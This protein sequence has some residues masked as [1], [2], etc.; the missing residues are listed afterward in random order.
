VGLTRPARW[1]SAEL[2]TGVAADG[3]EVVPE[4]PCAIRT[5]DSPD[6]GFDLRD[7]ALSDREHLATAFGWLH[8]LCSPVARI[9]HPDD[10]TV[11][12]EVLHEF[13]H[14]LLRHL[15]T[16]GEDAD[17]RPG[18]IKVLKDRPVRGAQRAM[19]PLGQPDDYEI[20]ERD[21][22]LRGAVRMPPSGGP[23]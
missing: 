23:P 12:F 11:G 3:F 2:R 1:K 7:E 19:P 22:R 21:E 15:G 16:L 8:E 9:R 10:V 4:F 17:R 20:V 18:V 13:G 5:D 6:P 14:G